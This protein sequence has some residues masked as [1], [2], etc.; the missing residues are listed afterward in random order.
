MKF[1]NAAALLSAVA[2]VTVA[3]EAE[4]HA[5]L[6]GSN[7]A[8]GATVAAPKQIVLK[9]SEKLQPAFSS[10]QLMKDDVEAASRSMVA[11]DRTTMI[12]TPARPLTAGAYRIHWRTVAGDTHKVQGDVAF[13]VR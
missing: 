7:P 12:V 11:K 9:F 2:A 13:I 4:A 10:A 3:A 5:R 6:V 1:R 8:Q